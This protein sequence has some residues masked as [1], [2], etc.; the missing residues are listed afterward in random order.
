MS[1]KR[2]E[3]YIRS[4]DRSFMREV[5]R[6]YGPETSQLIVK[7]LREYWTTFKGKRPKDWE[8]D[9]NR[10]QSQAWEDGQEE[11]PRFEWEDK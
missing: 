9:I 11:V 6:V 1:D 8:R 10:V 5:K 2:I 3:M 7:L 4:R